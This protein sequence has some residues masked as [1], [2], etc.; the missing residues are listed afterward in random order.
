MTAKFKIIIGNIPHKVAFRDW[1][2]E[3]MFEMRPEIREAYQNLPNYNGDEY[4]NYETTRVRQLGAEEMLMMYTL[5]QCLVMMFQ[6]TPVLMMT[7]LIVKLRLMMMETWEMM[8][9]EEIFV[10]Y[11]YS[12]VVD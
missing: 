5:I 4:I 3:N 12:R 7:L 10:L 1:S 2:V 11:S 9:G 8:I 6:V